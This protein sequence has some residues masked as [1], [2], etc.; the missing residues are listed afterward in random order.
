MRAQLI[1][2]HLK[3]FHS[4][5]LSCEK[6]KRSNRRRAPRQLGL[7]NRRGRREWVWGREFI[8]ESETAGSLMGIP[9][10]SQRKRESKQSR[11]KINSSMKDWKRREILEVSHSFSVLWATLEARKLPQPPP[12]SQVKLSGSGC[13]SE[14]GCV[15]E[16]GLISE[17]RAQYHHLRA[18]QCEWVFSLKLCRK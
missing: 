15:R 9:R 3:E 2:S 8:W 10:T 1:L 13:E 18:A 16:Y 6:N 5:A 12:N 14:E 4:E 7:H 11:R 17:Q